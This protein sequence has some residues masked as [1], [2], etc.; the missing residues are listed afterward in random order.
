MQ[1]DVSRR[2]ADKIRATTG[3]EYT[4]G[5]GHESLCKSSFVCFISRQPV[6]ESS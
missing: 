1:V 4:Y 2:A 6:L 3:K 5:P